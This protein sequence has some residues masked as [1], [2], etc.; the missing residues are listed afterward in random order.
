MALK[1]HRYSVSIYPLLP[2]TRSRDVSLIDL[3]ERE[4]TIFFLVF[5]SSPPRFVVYLSFPSI[6]RPACLSLPILCCYNH[7]YYYYYYFPSYWTPMSPKSSTRGEGW[8]HLRLIKVVVAAL[9]KEGLEA[10]GLVFDL[11]HELLHLL[12]RLFLLL[13]VLRHQPGLFCCCCC[14]CCYYYYYYTIA[15]TTGAAALHE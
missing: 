6:H 14:C 7:Y 2:L 10:A 4:S 3:S 15:N 8:L 11:V 1:M 13:L 12:R 5:S 9:S